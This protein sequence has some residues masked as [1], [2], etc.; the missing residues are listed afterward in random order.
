[1][2]RLIWATALTSILL[3]ACSQSEQEKIQVDKASYQVENAIL[4]QQ[5]FEQL[6]HKLVIDFKKFKQVES[7]AFAN[8]YPLDPNNLKSLNL[9]LVA[10]TALKP[11]K[12]AYCQLMNDYF[13]QMYRLGH[14]NLKLLNDVQLPNSDQEDLS[15]NFAS[16]NQFY[17]FILN[18]YTSY[19]QVQQ[20]MGYGCN[21]KSALQS[22]E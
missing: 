17:D 20:V 22:T 19:R 1:M 21:L 8:Q 12:I 10:S 16:A 9:H 7:L 11:T 6:N 14:Y 5:R 2:K 3:T 18:R 13:T 15:K 4:L